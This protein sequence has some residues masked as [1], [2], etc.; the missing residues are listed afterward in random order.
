MISRGAGSMTEFKHVISL[1]H[2][3]ATANDLE[4]IGL[5]SS[6]GPLDWCESHELEKIMLL[7]QNNFN[8]F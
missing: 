4:R 5:R 6:S 3:C 8:G 1:G 2:L 7:I